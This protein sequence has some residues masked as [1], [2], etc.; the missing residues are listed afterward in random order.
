MTAIGAS[1]GER[2]LPARPTIGLALGGGGARGFAHILMLEACEALGVRPAIIAGTS[3]GAVIG[4]A[5]ASGLSARML[6][7][8]TEEALSQRFDVLRQLY[9]ARSEPVAR[10]LN[11][12]PIRSALLNPRVVLE[13]L[14]PGKVARSFAGLEIPLR[15]VATDFLAQEQIVLERGDLRTA[16][17]GS[18]ALP[19]L[20]APVSFEGRLLMDGALVNPLPFDVLA[21]AADITV[22]VDVSAG[23][24]GEAGRAAPSAL[25]ALI[26]A[27]QIMQRS[28]V[29]EKLASRRPDIYIDVEVD[30]FTVLDFHRFRAILD[31]AAPAQARL[32]REL[33]DRLRA[34]EASP[35]P[36]PS[37][38]EP[39]PTPSAAAPASVPRCDQS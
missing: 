5:Y 32:K 8:H 25:S 9:A 27:S 24:T 21:G 33:E 3:I 36:A 34:W 2:T 14:L 4:A 19:A 18:M 12:I 30:A 10:F 16:I 37:T 38:D 6:R 31:A 29:R 7:A 23:S 39:P 20:F 11:V 22:A 26:A 17:A 28:I 15:V 35:A 13:L 1:P